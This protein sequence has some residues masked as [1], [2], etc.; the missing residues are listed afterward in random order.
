VLVGAGHAH[1]HVLTGLAARPLP[2]VAVTLVSPYPR[3]HYSGMVPGYLQGTYEEP[4]LA[5]DLE[6]LCRAAGARRVEAFAERVDPAAGV[7]EAGG[8]R[9]AFDLA[10]LDVGSDAAALGVPGARAHAFTVRPM[11][12]AVALRERADE[13]IARARGG[14]L[15][16][17]V[18]GGGAAGVEVALALHRRASRGG[19]RPAVALVEAGPAILADYGAAVRQRALGILARRGVEVLTGRAVDEVAPDAVRLGDGHRVPADLTAWLTGAAP[20]ALLGA[21]PLPRDARGFFLVDGTLRSADGAPVW[22]A[23]DCVGL[24]GHPP[25]A[26]AGVYA[27]RQAPVLDR[28]LRAA[29]AGGPPATYA[30][31][32][33][34]LALLNTADGRA[35]LRWRGWVAHARWAWWLKDRI[36]RG[37]MRRYQRVA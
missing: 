37:F 22:G 21:S 23:G 12:R 26:K 2:D 15:A 34:F 20:P 5:F 13:V 1:V 6:R 33:S 31:Q 35:L 32:A 28:N 17:A 14:T 4:A 7:V 18:V 9:L 11:T 16:V 10:S 30:P 24:A 8:A 27:V 36:D 3:H 19:A 25:L 29:L